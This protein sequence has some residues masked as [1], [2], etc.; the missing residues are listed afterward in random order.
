MK[1]VIEYILLVTPFHCNLGH[2]ERNYKSILC[3]HKVSV[4]SMLNYC[5]KFEKNFVLLKVDRLL[6]PGSPSGKC[7]LFL[8]MHQFQINDIF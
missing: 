5:L 3:Q 8:S 2:R 7:Y 6:N 4:L 1:M